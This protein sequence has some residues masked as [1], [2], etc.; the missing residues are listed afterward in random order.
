MEIRVRPLCRRSRFAGGRSAAGGDARLFCRRSRALGPPARWRCPALLPPVE[1]RGGPLCR[2]LRVAAVSP[3]CFYRGEATP[4]PA[5]VRVNPTLWSNRRS[6]PGMGARGKGVDNPAVCGRAEGGR[7]VVHAVGGVRLD[8]GPGWSGGWRGG[9]ALREASSTPSLEGL[10]AT[11]GPATEVPDQGS[12]W[13]RRGRIRLQHMSGSRCRAH[14]RGTVA[15]EDTVT[16]A[17]GSQ[18]LMS[19]WVRR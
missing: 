7:V 19:M 14:P 8:C 13:A 3:R 9:P 15:G 12:G 1:I 17:R 6:S 4:P 10:I 11:P 2:R 16:A 5:H 18:G